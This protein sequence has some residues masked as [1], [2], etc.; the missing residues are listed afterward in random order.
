MPETSAE[1]DRAEHWCKGS[2]LKILPFIGKDYGGSQPKIMLLLESQYVPGASDG[3]AESIRGERLRYWNVDMLGRHIKRE[4]SQKLLTK[5]GRLL[6]QFL[7]VGDDERELLDR[8]VFYNFIQFM[9]PRGSR[10][11]EQ[12]ISQS[13]TAFHAVLETV[14]P[15]LVISFGQRRVRQYLEYA[16]RANGQMLDSEGNF[17]PLRMNGATILNTMHP[18][19]QFSYKGALELLREQLNECSNITGTGQALRINP[20][21]PVVGD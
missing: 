11:N 14:A 20:P 12:Q 9:I 8:M 4:E 16:A 17:S 15:E 13:V 18:A 5:V 21:Q 1:R 7:D 19:S 6:Q 2:E 10:A 3:G